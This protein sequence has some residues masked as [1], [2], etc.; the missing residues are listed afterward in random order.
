MDHKELSGS[1]SSPNERKEADRWAAAEY[2]RDSAEQR[3]ERAEDAVKIVRRK[4]RP[5]YS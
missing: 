4:P 1:N 5:L 3:R 2:S